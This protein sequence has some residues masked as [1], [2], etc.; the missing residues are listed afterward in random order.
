[1]SKKNKSTLFQ[2]DLLAEAI[3]QSFVKL[4]PKLLFRNPVMFTVEIGTVVM[5]FVCVW[6]LTGENH[7]EISDTISLFFSSYC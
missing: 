5:L 1:M 7:K 4:N 6:I 2:K 3:R